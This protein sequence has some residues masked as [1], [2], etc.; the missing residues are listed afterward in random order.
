M[1]AVQIVTWRRI[2]VNESGKREEEK[3]QGTKSLEVD[4]CHLI[5]NAK[6][7]LDMWLE[8]MFCHSVA[9]LFGILHI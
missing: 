5:E 7:E 4:L 2:Q 9:M 3:A 8:E 6:R 1:L